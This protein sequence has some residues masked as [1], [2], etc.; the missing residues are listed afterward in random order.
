MRGGFERATNLGNAMGQHVPIKDVAMPDLGLGLAAAV[1]SS[2]GLGMGGAQCRDAVLVHSH[3]R[4]CRLIGGRNH[5]V[6]IEHI[7]RH[8]RHLAGSERV[9]ES[10][11]NIAKHRQSDR[12]LIPPPGQE[13]LVRCPL[14]KCV[15]KVVEP[16]FS[17]R[18][19]GSD[20]GQ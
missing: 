18:P 15:A 11:G 7:A 4:K 13:S 12:R 17:F 14:V 8:D 9:E 3:H 16:D 5:S 1:K 2:D 6:E 20:P 10:R 19:F